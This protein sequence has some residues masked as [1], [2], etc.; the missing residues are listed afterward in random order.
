MVVV[1]SPPRRRSTVTVVQVQLG[2]WAPQGP[3]DGDHPGGGFGVAVQQAQMVL[4][5]AADRATRRRT[6]TVRRHGSA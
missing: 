1:E 4:K 5:C 6:R 2:A 3:L